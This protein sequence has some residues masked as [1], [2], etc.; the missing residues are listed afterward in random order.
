MPALTY[1]FVQVGHFTTDNASNNFTFLEE[2]DV[3][4]RKEDPNINFD[5]V[6]NHIACFVEPRD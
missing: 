5:P 6:K 2:L 4:L 3:L 1:R